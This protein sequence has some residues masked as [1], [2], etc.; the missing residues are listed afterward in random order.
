M[1]QEL[2][3]QFNGG[4]RS[5]AKEIRALKMKSI[6]ASHYKLTR[7][8]WEHHQSWFPTT[9]EVAEKL[10][11]NYSTVVPHLNQNGKVK[12]LDKW[13]PRVVIQLLSCVRLSATSWTCSM[14]GFSDLYRLLEL[15]LKSIKSVMSL[16]ASWADHKSK[17]LSFWSVIFSYSTQ[18][19]WTISWSDCDMWW[20]V[21]FIWQ[22][23]NTSWVAGPRRIFKALP[24]VK[25]APKKG[26][27]HCLVVCYQSDPLRLSESQQNHYIWEVCSANWWA[28]LKT[29]RPAV[30]INQQKGP[31][32]SV[33]QC[34]IAHHTTN[35]S[36]VERIGLWSF[37][38]P[39]LSPTDYHSS[40]I[41]TSFC[42]EN[43]STNSRK[44]FLTVR[45]TLEHRFLCH[46]NKQTYFSLARMCWL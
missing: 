37:A 23:A 25:R 8:T 19:K 46:T 20:K 38:S 34:P 45:W 31:N 28:A 10:N 32:S 3:I 11:V 40:S 24:K 14:P 1:A 30:S 16:S 22:M 39:D 9:G 29:A 2:L 13:V 44:C 7:T 18:Q 26:H 15:K 21:D 43:A 41:L 4:S 12:K 5:I 42:R 35:A 36:K 17:K 33:W 6:V 27:G